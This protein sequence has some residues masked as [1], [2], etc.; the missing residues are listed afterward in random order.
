MS[1]A[2]HIERLILDGIALPPGGERHLQAA[3]EAELVRLLASGDLARELRGGAV[4]AVRI[5]GAR[6]N[7]ARGPEALGRE[8]ARTVYNGLG[9]PAQEKGASE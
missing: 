3:V 1:I 7:G 2:L 8:I 4:P 9:R 5:S 6:L